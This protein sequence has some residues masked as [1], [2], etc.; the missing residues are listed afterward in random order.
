V[1]VHGYLDVDLVTVHRLLNERLEDFSE[2]ARLIERYLA[3][4]SGQ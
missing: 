1:I 3:S 2:F 4:E